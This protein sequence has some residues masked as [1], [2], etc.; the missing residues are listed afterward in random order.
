MTDKI[1][2][3]VRAARLAGASW[4]GNPDRDDVVAEVAAREPLLLDAVFECTGDPAAL[5]QAADLLT[6]GG[7]LVVVGIPP[8]PRVSLDIHK[9]RRKEIALLNVRRQRHCMSEAIDF[10][11]RGAPIPRFMLTHRFGI[12]EGARAFELAA[13]YRDGAIKTII[14]I[15]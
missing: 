3:R 11:A 10:I 7:R 9:L 8:A 1:D 5:D 13:G 14:R 4:A 15:P 6:P 2:D 12:D